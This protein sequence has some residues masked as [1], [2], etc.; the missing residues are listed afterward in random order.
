MDILVEVTSRRISVDRIVKS[1]FTDSAGGTVV[2]IGTVRNSS[3]GVPKVT[4]VEL[5]AARDL[6]RADLL[7]ISRKA[8]ST[9]DISRLAVQHRVGR[10][11]VGDVI[12]VIAV[13]APHRKA[14]FSA[15][16]FVIDELKKSTPIW[17][18][19]FGTRGSAW[20]V[21]ER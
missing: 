14:A 13:S 15:C 5:E 8:I 1:V 21:P 10:L 12:L 9:Y 7:R 3:K 18:K 20:V 4:G 6:A 19:E 11:S 16:R 2:F 17:K